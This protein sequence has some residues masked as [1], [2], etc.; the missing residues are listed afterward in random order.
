L[1]RGKGRDRELN[2]NLEEIWSSGALLLMDVRVPL[3]SRI[4]FRA[5][6][7][8]FR[9]QVASRRFV[10]GLGYYV[11]VRFA[12]NSYWSEQEYRP[13]HLLNPLV[14]LAN[15]IFAATPHPP[16]SPP[17][18]GFMP[19]PAFETPMGLARRHAV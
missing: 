3:S 9:G 7:R 5:A 1:K 6:D 11:E 17:T 13:Q 14:L 18:Q 16:V 2:A 19:Q 8:K 15:K 12:S 10:K 4:W